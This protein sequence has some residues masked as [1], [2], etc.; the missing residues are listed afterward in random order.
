MGAATGLA[1]DTP[2]DK[3]ELCTISLDMAAI[4]AIADAGTGT[5]A[6]TGQAE[7]FHPLHDIIIR[8]LGNRVAFI[9]RYGY[10]SLAGGLHPY[11]RPWCFERQEADCGRWAPAFFLFQWWP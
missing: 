3:R 5:A 11:G 2:D 10:H 9:D 8:F 7:G 1:Q 4:G 6:G